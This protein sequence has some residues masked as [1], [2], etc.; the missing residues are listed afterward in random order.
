MKSKKGQMGFTQILGILIFLYF[1]FVGVV[2]IANMNKGWEALTYGFQKVS[3]ILMNVLGPLL[4]FIL[5]LGADTNTNFLMVLSFILI[6]IIITGTLDSV[7]IFGDDKNGG[8]INLAI[9]IIVSII[10]VRF[11]P[12]DIWLSLTAP[13]SAFVATILVGAPF[14]ALFF[15]TMKIKFNLA[16]KLLWLFY[17]LFMSY[18]IFFPSN[19]TGGATTGMLSGQND[20]AWIYLIFLVLAAIMMFFDA[21]V[22]RYWYREKSKLDVEKDLASLGIKQRA[23]LRKEIREWQEIIADSSASAVD[24]ASAKKQLNKAKAMYGDIS[25]I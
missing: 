20:F 22:R 3:E 10:G 1:I 5:N 9:G 21:T 14:A 6:C 24:I 17:I 11:M 16:R 18:L 19:L 25:S 2:A 13:S 23:R 12:Q 4:T 8:L 7:N 15:V